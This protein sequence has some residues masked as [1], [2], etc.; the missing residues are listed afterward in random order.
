MAQE[1]S[2]REWELYRDFML[3]QERL[4][5]VMLKLLEL[6]ANPIIHIREPGVVYPKERQ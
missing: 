3:R 5:D 4:I 1:N 2:E 6:K